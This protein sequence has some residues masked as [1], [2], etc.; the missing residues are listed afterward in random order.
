MGPFDDPSLSPVSRN[1]L[2]FLLLFASR[3][4]MKNSWLSFVLLFEI[5]EFWLM[6]HTDSMYYGQRTSQFADNKRHL[7]RDIR[8][9]Q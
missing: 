9:C 2:F 5:S 1:R 8:L 4:Q 3:T 7:F 6:F